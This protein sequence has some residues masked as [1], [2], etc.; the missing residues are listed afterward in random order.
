[1]L[2]RLFNDVATY[3]SPSVMEAA[4]ATAILWQANP[5]FRALGLA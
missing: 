5:V 2:G 3:A 1:M 4:F